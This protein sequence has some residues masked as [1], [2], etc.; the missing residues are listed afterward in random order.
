MRVIRWCCTG[1]LLKVDWFKPFNTFKPFK[2]YKQTLG[3]G[4]SEQPTTG[5]FSATATSGTYMIGKFTV[6]LAEL[7]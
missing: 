1:S 7:L 3:C 2:S 5:V 6:N 4:S